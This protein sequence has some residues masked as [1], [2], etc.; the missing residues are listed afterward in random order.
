M[1]E[2]NDDPSVRTTDK[3]VDTGLADRIYWVLLIVFQAAMG[4]EAVVLLVE[5]QWLNALLVI[6]I[7][8]VVIAPVVIAPRL[9][10][11]IPAEFQ[12]MTVIFVFATLFL[13]E[14]LNYYD[15]FAWW[16]TVLHAF[17][18]LLL[19]VF[20]FLLVYVLNENRRIEIALRPRFVALFAFVFAVAVGALWEI[21]EFAVDEMFGQSMQRGGLPDTMWD[22][23]ADTVAAAGISVFGWWYL[24]RPEHSFIELW[25]EKFIR[26]N[27]RMFR[28]KANGP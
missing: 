2:Q 4:I 23:I 13:G 19:G 15:R 1:D 27:P 14:T 18:G 26:R 7:M 20:G 21:F 10:V 3:A 5:Q 25:V 12:A 11:R 8:A 28:D 16:D 22:L 24:H 6:G 17:S 9:H